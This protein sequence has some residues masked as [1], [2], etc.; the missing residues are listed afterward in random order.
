M[1][2]RYLHGIR[3]WFALIYFLLLSFLFLDFRNLF[4]SFHINV[5]QYLQFIP[6]FLKFFNVAGIS[7]AGFIIVMLFTILF[8]RVY[9]SFICP[10]GIFQDLISK[11]SGWIRKGRNFKF[12]RPYNWLRY[13]KRFTEFKG[14]LLG[15]ARPH[16]QRLQHDY[17][18][19]ALRGYC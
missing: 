10:L 16:K 8:G 18:H 5:L 15:Y 14:S 9:C 2:L 12:S 19:Q 13:L 4:S 1:K 3:I 11:L 6:S 7:A 17:L